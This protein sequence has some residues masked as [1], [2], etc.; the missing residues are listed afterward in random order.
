MPRIR[1]NKMPKSREKYLPVTPGYAKIPIEEFDL[2]KVSFTY[3]DS[4]PTFG[5][6]DGKEY[7]K[8]V[9][10]YEE[11]LELI[12]RH[13]FPQDWNADGVHGPERYIEAHVWTEEPIKKYK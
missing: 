13:G 7:R 12:D 10:T 9:Y 6:D 8:Q 2:K 5:Y 3:G 1:E 11:I 4:M